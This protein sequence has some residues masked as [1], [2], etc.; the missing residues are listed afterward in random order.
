[1]AAKMPTATLAAAH[2]LAF[3]APPPSR[4]RRIRLAALAAERL[5]LSGVRLR[6]ALREGGLVLHFQPILELATGEVRRYE[7]L[8][9]MRG[10]V[11]GS[12]HAPVRFLPGA[13]RSGLV[14]ELDRAVLR[15]ALLA[16]AESDVQLAV[17]LSALTVCAPGTLS[18]LEAVLD[19]HAVAPERLL[20]EITETAAVADFQLA[21]AFCEGAQRLGCAVALDD[22]G[23]GF[24]S[25]QYL[26]ELP[27]D[28]IKID[29]H[30]IRDLSRSH[31]DRVVVKALAQVARALG[32]E[33]VAEFVGDLET[34]ELL[35]ELG[36]DH[37]Q[38]YAVGRPRGT[39]EGAP[40]RF[41]SGAGGWLID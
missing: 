8:V 28:V 24:C 9:R 15:S 21:R 39:L 11:A 1:M 41:A 32:K 2:Q 27:F 18:Y 25:L 14:R 19:E 16:L 31:R 29:G 6:Q 4:P 5:C 34:I 13:E 23:V 35:R 20:I 40:R 3:S 38:G 30:F 17:N 10:E 22:F 33:T 7:A 37:A 12:L 36:I 26:T